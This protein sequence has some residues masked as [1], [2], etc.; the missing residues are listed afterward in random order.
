MKESLSYYRCPYVMKNDLDLSQTPLEA[1][2]EAE[3][4]AEWTGLI[5][6]H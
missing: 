2:L 5:Q 6:W 1:S 3:L 4:G